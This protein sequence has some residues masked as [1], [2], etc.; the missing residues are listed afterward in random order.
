[1][2]IGSYEKRRGEAREVPKNEWKKQAR[3]SH[4]GGGREIRIMELF[5]NE[6][7]GQL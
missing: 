6:Y 7:R 3:P 1:M 2:E 4:F 5:F